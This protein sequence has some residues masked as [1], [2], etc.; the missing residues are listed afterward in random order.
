[1]NE[2]YLHMATLPS[3]PIFSIISHTLFLT[4]SDFISFGTMNRAKQT[5]HSFLQIKGNVCALVPNSFWWCHPSCGYTLGWFFRGTVRTNSVDDYKI[6]VLH[7]KLRRNYL[8]LTK[9][10]PCTY[11]LHWNSP[12]SWCPFSHKPKRSIWSRFQL[13]W[14]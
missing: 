9:L 11:F 6:R 8:Y 3:S 4:S 13:V 2:H 1:M 14:L 10:F 5:D 12:T 7:T